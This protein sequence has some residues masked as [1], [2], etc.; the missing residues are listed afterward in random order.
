MSHNSSYKIS[1]LAGMAIVMANMIGTGAFTSLGIQLKGL[2]DPLAVL[3]LWVFGGLLAISGAF[4]YA[5]VGTTI[6]KSGGEFTFLS[7]IYHPIIG[8]LSGWISLLVGFAAP[9]ALAAI[10][11]TEYFHPG[12]IHAKWLAILLLAG[13]TFIHTQSLLTSSR[14]QLVSTLFNLLFQDFVFCWPNHFSSKPIEGVMVIGPSDGRE[15]LIGILCV[16]P[17]CMV[18]NNLLILNAES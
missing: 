12:G 9:I 15:T 13:I 11:F 6:R 14:F 18:S 1:T 7:E 5:E 16:A 10:A 17:H 3:T 2:Q 8:Y 4:S